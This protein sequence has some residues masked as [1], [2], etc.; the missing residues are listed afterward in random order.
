MA[1]LKHELQKRDL[2]TKGIKRKLVA[3]LREASAVGS[4]GKIQPGIKGIEAVATREVGLYRSACTTWSGLVDFWQSSKPS[5]AADD[6]KPTSL[7]FGANLKLNKSMQCQCKR[8]SG[9]KSQK[10]QSFHF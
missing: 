7:P 1:M 2:P 8:A 4:T 3:R 6:G 10:P 9:G 5:Q